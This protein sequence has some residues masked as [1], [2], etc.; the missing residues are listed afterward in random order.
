MDLASLIS[1]GA[2][3]KLSAVL[4]LLALA[5]AV[6]TDKL[7]WHTRLEKAEAQFK[8]ALDREEQRADRWERVALEALTAGAQAGVKAAETAVDVVSALPDPAKSSGG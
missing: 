8:E 7:I 2:V 3:D 1:L 6:I 4:V 5:L